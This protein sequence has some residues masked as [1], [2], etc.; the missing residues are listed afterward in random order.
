MHPCREVESSKCEAQQ[1]VAEV[2]RAARSDT[3]TPAQQSDQVPGQGLSLFEGSIG[4]VEMDDALEVL[5]PLRRELTVGQVAL[6]K[7]RPEWRVRLRDGRGGEELNQIP[8]SE[9]ILKSAR[10]A[11]QVKSFL[12]VDKGEMSGAVCA[13]EYVTRLQIAMKKPARMPFRHRP[14][15]VRT[16]AL[17]DLLLGVN[18]TPV[19]PDRREL[20]NICN[21]AGYNEA[22]PV[23]HLSVFP[24]GGE[25]VESPQSLTPQS[26]GGLQNPERIA[27][28]QGSLQGALAK[29]VTEAVDPPAFH[30]KRKSHDLAPGTI[31]KQ[32]RIGQTRH[33]LG[34]V[35]QQ[36]RHSE[37]GVYISGVASAPVGNQIRWLGSGVLLPLDLSRLRCSGFH[38][39]IVE[40]TP[41]LAYAIRSC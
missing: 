30:D 21:L 33:P 18:R 1:P 20:G 10:C 23:E 3:Q 8:C 14:C 12:Q 5:N 15:Q 38:A 25:N 13:H 37:P 41:Q 24:D 17:I 7:A 6:Q 26:T 31:Q 2:L 39:P 4:S 11:G 16:Q 36:V 29:V 19:V 9:R 27:A 32:L 28:P 40:H 35:Q 22:V 34:L